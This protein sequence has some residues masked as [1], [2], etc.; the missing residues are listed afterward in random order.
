M[1]KLKLRKQNTVERE[2]MTDPKRQNYSQILLINNM[3][4]VL[5]SLVTCYI[6]F[7]LVTTRKKTR[8]Y[9][10]S[11]YL[12]SVCAFFRRSWYFQIMFYL[13]YLIWAITFFHKAH[14]CISHF[15]QWLLKIIENLVIVKMKE[16]KELHKTIVFRDPVDLHIYFLKSTYFD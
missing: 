12:V 9:I 10:Y 1:R 4:K 8:I 7:V 3:L 13:L 6:I 14:L 15:S 16:C 11:T 5:K 2:S